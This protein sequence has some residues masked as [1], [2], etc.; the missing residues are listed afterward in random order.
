MNV[1]IVIP[2]EW[3]AS[4]FTADPR[5]LLQGFNQ[6]GHNATIVCLSGSTPADGAVVLQVEYRRLTDPAFWRTEGFDLV[7]VFTWMHSYND[8]LVA[9]RL[10]GA[11]VVAQWDTDGNYSARAQPMSTLRYA[12]FSAPPVLPRARNIWYW[13][14]R[15]AYLDR[16]YTR[17]IVANLQLADATVVETDPAHERVAQILRMR[18]ASHLAAKLHVVPLPIADAFSSV[19]VAAMRDE[20][21]I[22][23]VGRWKAA[24][25]NG[26]LLASVLRSY[27][28]ADDQAVAMVVGRGGAAL[29]GDVPVSRLQ[30]AEHLDQHDV[31]SIAG[32]ARVFLVTSRWE[33]CHIGAH[34]AVA[35]GASVVGTPIPAVQALTVNQAFGRVSRSH[36]KRDVL[37][38]LESEMA[39][40][41]RGGRS[42]GVI[43]SY[44]RERLEPRAVAARLLSLRDPANAINSRT[45]FEHQTR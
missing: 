36:R 12:F 32:K 4:T 8:V 35:A 3:H 42:P 41:D 24:Q 9:A 29:F 27:L 19:D 18:N 37:R 26:K 25:K 13:T 11:F 44:W 21:L 22:Y 20:R 7:L 2:T 30:T 15:F 40:W 6:L 28:Q 38:A 14:K 34:E 31:A 33:G 39:E 5:L 16:E 1:A 10:S 17:P 43:A 23:S 45:L